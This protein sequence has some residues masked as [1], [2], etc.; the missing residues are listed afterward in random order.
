VL[1]IIEFTFI[2]SLGML[3]D[4]CLFDDPLLP[5]RSWAQPRQSGARIR[6]VSFG[7]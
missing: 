1:F 2:L 4:S 7:R 6:P 3:I 5:S